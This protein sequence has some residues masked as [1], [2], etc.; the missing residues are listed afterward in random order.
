MAEASKAVMA[1]N[2]ALELRGVFF[3]RKA[4]RFVREELPREAKDDARD[5]TRF[6]LKRLD[7]TPPEEKQ[8][9]IEDTKQRM[10]GKEEP[11]K[12]RDYMAA[13]RETKA[14]ELG[15]QIVVT[16]WLGIPEGALPAFDPGPIIVLINAIVDALIRLLGNANCPLG[17]AV[18]GNVID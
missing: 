6:M 10:A 1:I 16:D 14:G 13:V 7:A 8:A 11:I 3:E 2:N 5:L 12:G 9:I 18:M 17:R 4:Y 15:Y